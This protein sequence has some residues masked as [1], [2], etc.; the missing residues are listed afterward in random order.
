M[1]AVAVPLGIAA[2]SCSERVVES[3]AGRD[4]KVTVAAAVVS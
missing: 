1:S 4:P 3:G 2:R